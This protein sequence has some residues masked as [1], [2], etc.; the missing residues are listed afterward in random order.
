MRSVTANSRSAGRVHALRDALNVRKVLRPA[1][2]SLADF[3]CVRA[4]LAE[5]VHETAIEQQAGIVVVLGDQ[6][7]FGIADRHQ[8]VRVFAKSVADDL[9]AQPLAG[10]YGDR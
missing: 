10:P 8:R 5:L 2:A 9:D 3:D 4:G 7:A 1:E 6:L